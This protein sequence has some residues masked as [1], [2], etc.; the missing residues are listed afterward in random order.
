MGRAALRVTHRCRCRAAEVELRYEAD[1]PE[2]LRVVVLDSLTAIYH[3]AS[4]QTHIVV[5]PAPEILAALGTGCADV[6]QLCERLDLS[7]NDDTRMVLAE[8]LEELIV[9]GLIKRI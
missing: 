2:G 5:Q 6:E 9:T 4:G 1:P 7:D 8:R 3:R